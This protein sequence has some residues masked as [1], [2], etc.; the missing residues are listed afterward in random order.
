MNF[1]VER[2]YPRISENIR[3]F[4]DILSQ[5]KISLPTLTVRQVCEAPYCGCCGCCECSGRTFMK[6][7]QHQHY[8]IA[9]SSK[10]SAFATDIAFMHITSMHYLLFGMF[11]FM[12]KRYKHPK[13]TLGCGMQDD[14]SGTHE[15]TG[16]FGL[17]AKSKL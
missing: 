7:D 12:K 13:S 1:F 16:V 4:W 3:F 17:L 8:L 6:G 14:K 5:Q 15:L 11:F 2:E 10:L 9:M